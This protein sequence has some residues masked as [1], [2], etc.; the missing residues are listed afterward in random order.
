[1]VSATPTTATTTRTT[2]PTRADGGGRDLEHRAVVTVLD[3]G[4]RRE[5]DKTSNSPSPPTSL[6]LP[7]ILSYL[8][9]PLLA[10]FPTSTDISSTPAGFPSRRFDFGADIDLDD[11]DAT[12]TSTTQSLSSSSAHVELQHCIFSFNFPL[13]L[14]SSTHFCQRQVQPRSTPI[15]Y[16]CCC[17]YYKFEWVRL[18]SLD[19]QFTNFLINA[20]IHSERINSL[21]DLIGWVSDFV[22]AIDDLTDSVLIELNSRLYDARIDV[23]LNKA[24]GVEIEGQLVS[25]SEVHSVVDL[26]MDLS[27]E[28]TNAASTDA[29]RRAGA[30]KYLLSDADWYLLT[31]QAADGETIAVF[32][33]PPPLGSLD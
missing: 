20:L 11:P 5:L 21:E 15:R 22:Q 23:E 28:S 9:P 30:S 6:P 1:M 31:L 27:F 10:P 17:C 3:P 26:G 16:G 8:L 32:V 13:S 19:S 7:S 29:V 24:F 2:T 33:Q 25:G 14:R 4:V 18:D 12:R